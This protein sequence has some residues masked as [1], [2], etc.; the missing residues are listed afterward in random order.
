ME[1]FVEALA[2]YS[3]LAGAVVAVLLVLVGVLLLCC[4]RLLRLALRYCGG[5]ACIAA[6]TGVLG[7]MVSALWKTK[8]S[9]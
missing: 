7:S 6:G 3:L 1:R 4:P 2:R 8:K 9:K 5:V